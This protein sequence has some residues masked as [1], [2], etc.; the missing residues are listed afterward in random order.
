MS[1]I[2]GQSIDFEQSAES[3]GAEDSIWPTFTDIMTVVLM[4]FMFSMLVVVLKN[5][6]LITEL[7][8]T[9]R[10]EQLTKEQLSETQES[11][12][13]L[14]AR[15]SLLEQALRAKEMKILLLGDNQKMLD[16]KLKDQNAQLQNMQ[17]IIGNLNTEKQETEKKLAE[18]EQ[19][20]LVLGQ[21]KKQVEE[22][23]AQK[24]SQMEVII[25]DLRGK[26][27]ETE[28]AL[29]NQRSVYSALE[30]KYNKLIGPA[31]SPIDKK[32]VTVRLARQGGK[33]VFD[34]QGVGET[35]SRR[36]SDQELHQQLQ[37]YKDKYGKQLY[38]K[39]VI[40]KGANFSYN[41]AWEITNDLLT[42]YDY[43]YQ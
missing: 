3:S 20:I 38:V 40:P 19:T 34:L 30:E 43:Y 5:T 12:S 41:E 32:V 11:E 8:R 21:Q 15:T 42:R 23:A 35:E 36:V 33:P 10:T 2:F 27:Q 37:Q 28:L 13:A 6:E 16:Q 18:N 26:Q 14:R 7:E 22:E 31:R 9:L 1:H 39:I 29:A 24:L 17:V 25:T 4:I